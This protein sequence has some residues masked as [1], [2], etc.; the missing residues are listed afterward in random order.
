MICARTRDLPRGDPENQVD[1]EYVVV[2]QESLKFVRARIV[3][4]NVPALPC[5]YLQCHSSSNRP[6]HVD[7]G[8]F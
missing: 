6:G 4:V 5:M 3:G 8:P 2:I 1:G 7:V